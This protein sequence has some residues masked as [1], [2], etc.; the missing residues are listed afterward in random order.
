MTVF[1][2]PVGP[3]EKLTMKLVQAQ[4]LAGVGPLLRMFAKARGVQI[5]PHTFTERRHLPH[6]G[7]VVVHEKTRIGR[8]VT[9]FHGVT[10]G[11]SNIWEE[12]HED[13]VGF[14]IE[15]DAVLCANAAVLCE[16]GTVTVGR[17]TIIGANSV[18]TRSTGR[19]EIWAGAPARKVGVRH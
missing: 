5:P 4:K 16:R 6:V 12:P 8:N 10:I 9:L 17:G 11:R 1:R 7:T 19:D 2:T 14:V 18:L 3:V 15:D 13:F